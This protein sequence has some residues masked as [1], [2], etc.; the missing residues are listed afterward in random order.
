MLALSVCVGMGAYCAYGP[1]AVWTDKSNY[2]YW[3]T[4]T[5]S[6]SGFRPNT[7]IVINITRPDTVVDTRSS[8]SDVSGNFV[9]YYVLNGMFGTYTVLASDG[10]QSATTTFLEANFIPELY[11]YSLEPPLGWTHG[12]VKGYYE[13][14]WVPFKIE[15]RTA[16]PT[17][18]ALLKVV[19]HHDYFDGLHYGLDQD[20][21]FA[22][23]RNGN[24]ESPTIDG[25]QVDGWASGI[26]QLEFNWTV[27]VNQGDN[28]TLY[29]ETHVAIG[30]HNYPG[31]KVHTVIYEIIAPPCTPITHG[32]RDVPIVCKGAQPAYP[33]T[34]VTSLS[35]NPMGLGGSVTDTITISTSAGGTLPAA[36]GTWTLYAADNS[37]MT[38]ASQIGTG[39]VSGALPFVVTSAAWP[40]PYAG[41]WF[42]QAVYSGDNNYIASHSDPTTECLTVGPAAPSVGTQLSATS[43]TLGQSVTDTVTVTGLGNGFPGPTGTV[44]FQVSKDGGATWTKFGGTMTLSGGSATSDSY[45][46]LAAGTYYFKAV[47]GGDGNY[48]SVASGDTAECLTVG[49]AAPSVGTQLSK[50]SVT[51]GDSV[52]DS[53]TVT[54]LGGSFPV[55]TG[56][57][58]FY[59]KVPGGASF[60][61]F[62]AVKTLS[63]GS[64]TSDSYTPL[65]AGTYYF[66]AVYGGDGNYNSAVSGDT[67]ERL[68]VALPVGGEW[69]PITLQTLSPMNTFQLLASWITLVALIG[70][71]AG[72]IV[73]GKFRKKR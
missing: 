33:T 60:V 62:G 21:N 9:Y 42:F 13:C 66:K 19:V 2:G 50:T 46:P 52:T 17:G 14:Q 7:N 41:N 40:P 43:I 5:I 1:T 34:A 68:I 65:A 38:G 70:T 6:G 53:V 69:A 44:D 8:V 73:Y 51:L 37:G 26:Q 20:R 39:S 58:T 12:D 64:A 29:W 18:S 67:A 59:V 22:M 4:V 25:P 30:A 24:P 15:L 48:N 36:S 55:P 45:A 28:C 71:A 16:G 47:Y 61:Q 57:V 23:W 49:P 32:D 56:T 11:G 35:A 72:S 31:S 3:E 63:G 54:G 27:T 10:V